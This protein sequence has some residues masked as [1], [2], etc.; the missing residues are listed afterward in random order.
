MGVSKNPIEKVQK[1]LSDH[2]LLS[3]ATVSE[4]GTPLARTLTYVSEGTVI[5]FATS[6]SSGKVRDILQNPN[7]AFT[8]DDAFTEDWSTI[9]GIQMEG[10]ASILSDAVELQKATG[11]LMKKYPQMAK[12]PAGQDMVVIKVEPTAGYFMDNS[13]GFGYRDRIVIG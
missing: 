2:S 7:V 3:L 13:L 9:Q 1:Y 4:Q 8:V 6:K 5:Y 11:L 10:R 12:M